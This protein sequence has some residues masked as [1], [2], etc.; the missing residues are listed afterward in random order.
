MRYYKTAQTSNRWTFR[1]LIV[2]LLVCIALLAPS[3]RERLL[4]LSSANNLTFAAANH[5]QQP[6]LQHMPLQAAPVLEPSAEIAQ[7]EQLE[8]VQSPLQAIG[9]STPSMDQEQDIPLD[10]AFGDPNGILPEGT[11]VFNAEYPGVTKL[12]SALLAALREAAKSASDNAVDFY[13]TSGW[14]SPAYQEQLL[15]EA[16]I[17][18][19]SQ[20]E[21]MRWVATADR[22]S[23][24][25]GDAV[26]IGQYN[27]MD[28][29]AQH[30]AEYG[31]CQIYANEP[32][33]YELRPEAREQGC[34]Q[35]YSDPSHDPRM[36][37]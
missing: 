17:E 14:R 27:A 24:V 20:E 25:S 37:P 10:A 7:A 8:P 34:P 11:S 35:M 31:L 2:A 13:V 29:L 32:W 26:D 19:G 12:N 22:S 23:H 6:R 28:W 5:Y 4:M 36:Q 15:R 9:E 33:H 30:G 21:A 3:L 1:L 18:Y 16:I